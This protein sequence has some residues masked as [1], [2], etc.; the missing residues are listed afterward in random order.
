MPLITAGRTSGVDRESPAGRLK[1]KLGRF[2]GLRGEQAQ[3]TGDH[4]CKRD[5]CCKL[6][7]LICVHLGRFYY[8]KI[9]EHISPFDSSE[10]TPLLTR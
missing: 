5:N 7:H 4:S 8:G 2:G 1:R 6:F 9:G 10:P 3:A